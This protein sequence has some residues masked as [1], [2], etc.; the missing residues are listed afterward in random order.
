MA[1]G[2]L[3]LGEDQQN[4]S[5]SSFVG[6]SLWSQ[7]STYKRK[8][9]QLCNFPFFSLISCSSSLCEDKTV[10][11]NDPCL[12]WFVFWNKRWR[13]PRVSAIEIWEYFA[14]IWEQWEYSNCVVFHRMDIT[15]MFG[16]QLPHVGIVFSWRINLVVFTF[17]YPSF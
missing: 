3:I 13:F 1:M 14:G 2:P 7:V 10:E 4:D 12:F 16:C 6:Y 9:K 11:L 8:V 17:L 15:M 5:A